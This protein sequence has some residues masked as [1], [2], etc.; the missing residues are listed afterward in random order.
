MQSLNW[1]RRQFLKA[2]SLGLLG[3]SALNSRAFSEIATPNNY[4]EAMLGIG[5]TVTIGP[6]LVASTTK[7]DIQIEIEL[8]KDGL[9][10]SDSF[11]IVHGGYLGR[12]KMEFA[13][14]PSICTH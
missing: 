11:G 5:T 9:K 6:T 1:E 3:L 4:L 12:W 8:G 2:T 14:T 7:S 13:E 10:A